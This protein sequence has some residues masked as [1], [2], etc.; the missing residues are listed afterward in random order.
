[1]F[2]VITLVIDVVEGSAM[3]VINSSFIFPKE[4]ECNYSI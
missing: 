1:M 3:L 2:E 4:K